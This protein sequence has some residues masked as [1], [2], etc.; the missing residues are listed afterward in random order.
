MR[1]SALAVTAVLL[2]S[3]MGCVCTGERV[4][5]V[6]LRT[7]EHTVDLDG[8][9]R[10]VMDIDM[11]IGKLT[12]R[13]GAE[14]LMEAEFTYNVEEWAP[15]VEYH[16]KDGRGVLTITQ[17]DAEGKSAP[18]KA[19]NEW[20]LVL[21]EDV[22][23]ELN[24]DMGV[25]GATMDL[26]DLRL[27]DLTVDHGVGDLKIDLEGEDTGDLRASI[28]GGVGSISVVV[29]TAVG[30]RVDAD[31]GIGAFH[32]CGLRKSGDSHVNDAYGETD[33]TIRL[34]VDAGIGK[35]SVSTSD[36]EYEI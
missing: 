17:P 22:P 4:E 27:T 33:S 25:G 5:L 35:I 36:E 7:E 31:T 9:E 19:K 13:S 30:V 10:V 26:G 15:E 11:G 8:A 24:I 14:A 1:A 20:V 21:N 34:S 28:D 2:L 6:D 3:M 23:L 18:N 12:V 32:T 16:V 29:P